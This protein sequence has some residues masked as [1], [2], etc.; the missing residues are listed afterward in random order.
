MCLQTLLSKYNQQYHKLFQDI[1]VEEV[2]LKGELFPGAAG[3]APGLPEARVL[4]Q[5]PPRH[6]LDMA[7]GCPSGVLGSFP[8]K[9]VRRQR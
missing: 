5:G 4:P 9:N 6:D 2:V 8:F 3:Q 1:P 7:T